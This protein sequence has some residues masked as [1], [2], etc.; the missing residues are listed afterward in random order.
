MPSHGAKKRK[1]TQV[2]YNERHGWSAKNP[3]PKRRRNGEWMGKGH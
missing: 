1:P 3:A 2:R